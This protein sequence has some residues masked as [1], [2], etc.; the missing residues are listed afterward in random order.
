MAMDKVPLEIRVLILVTI[1]APLLIANVAL[2][3]TAKAY[4]VED[5]R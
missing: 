3:P 1:L 4:T 2:S 5:A